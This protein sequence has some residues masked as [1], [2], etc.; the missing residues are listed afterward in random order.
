MTT[1]IK[2]VDTLRGRFST[3]VKPPLYRGGRWFLSA[4]LIIAAYFRVSPS[5]FIWF[6]GAARRYEA[7]E[8]SGRTHYTRCPGGGTSQAGCRGVEQAFGRRADAGTYSRDGGL[9]N[10]LI[11]L[12]RTYDA[13]IVPSISD[14]QP[15]I[16]VR[17]LFA[18]CAN[19]SEQYAGTQ[20][21][22]S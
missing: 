8:R 5:H 15:R 11:A 14:L 2:H 12:V 20:V 22:R 9:R 3:Y 17:C 10:S 19:F 7:T 1:G 18:S 6:A 13:V 21:L 4:L 16:V